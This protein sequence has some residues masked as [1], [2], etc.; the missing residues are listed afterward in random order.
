M[1]WLPDETLA[2][3]RGVVG[4]AAADAPPDLRGTPYELREMLG[5]GGMGTVYLAWDRE[6]AREVAL[7][8]VHAEAAAALAHR[9][10]REARTLARLE[11]PGIVP[12]HDV[13]ELPDGRIYYVMKRVRGERLDAALRAMPSLAER[14][15]VFERICE[16]VAFAHA[17]GVVHRDLK[18]ENVM[19]GEFGETLVL[20]WGAAKTL[21]DAPAPGLLPDDASG[22]TPITGHGMV[23]GTP[24]YMA[25]EQARGDS[26]DVD[27]RADVYSLGAMLRE[28]VRPPEGG[29]DVSRPLRAIIAHAMAPSPDERYPTADALAEDVRRAR[30]G[31]SVS[32]YRE[33]LFERAGRLMMRYRV[34]LLLVLTYLAMRVVLLLL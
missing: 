27:A 33:N 16:A 18:P 23:I 7:K 20:D 6:L 34:P 31:E 25:P 26:A 29:G 5:R 14:L 3:L 12:V 28:L 11:H 13:G 2:H 32:V 10:V 1:T 15:G 21:G 24:G 22:R 9:V 30:D 17:H 19:L 8:V 4:D